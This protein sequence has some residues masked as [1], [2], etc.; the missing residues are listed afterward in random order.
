[1]STYNFSSPPF[2]FMDVQ[3]PADT[4]CATNDF[5]CLPV[6]FLNQLQFQVLCETD[7]DNFLDLEIFASVFTECGSDGVHRNKNW[8]STWHKVSAD[9]DPLV[10]AG[11]FTSRNSDGFDTLMA[12]DCFNISIYIA[13]TDTNIFQYCFTQCFVKTASG[14]QQDECYTTVYEYRDSTNSFGFYYSAPDFD[15]FTNIIRLPTYLHSPVNVE[16]EKSYAKSD[17]STKKLMH[18]IW[19][20][21]QVKTDYFPAGWLEKFAIM[22]AH[23]ELHVVDA[24]GGVNDYMV[25]MEKVEIDWK[26]SDI[27]FFKLAQGKTTL[28]LAAP[29][30]TL[31]TNC[32]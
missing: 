28:R 25:R 17:G 23:S 2:S 31:N 4:D 21:Y 26:E 20:D 7:D 30:Q 24:Y 29:R 11:N 12:G 5:P 18:R 22:T 13:T 32:S 8:T 27:P 14:D 16:E 9:G 6:Q 1:M 10:F 19:K 15:T 3:N